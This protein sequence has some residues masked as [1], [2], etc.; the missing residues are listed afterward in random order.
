MV[1]YNLKKNKIEFYDK[2]KPNDL[3][4]VSIPIPKKYELNSSIIF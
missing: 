4:E 1:K 2:L 3:R